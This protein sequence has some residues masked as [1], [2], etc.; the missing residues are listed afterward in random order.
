MLRWRRLATASY[1]KPTRPFWRCRSSRHAANHVECIETCRICPTLPETTSRRRVPRG[2]QLPKS[3]E[4]YSAN[5]PARI[6]GSVQPCVSFSV[7]LKSTRPRPRALPSRRMM[8]VVLMGA[9][10]DLLSALAPLAET[11]IIPPSPPSPDPPPRVRASRWFPWSLRLH[12]YL[13]ERNNRGSTAEQVPRHVTST[14]NQ[15]NLHWHIRRW[16]DETCNA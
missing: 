13:V 9:C 14:A 7:F 15:A 8:P 4:A 1:T 6:P 5:G 3:F 16:P 11:A 2:A 10:A 12:V